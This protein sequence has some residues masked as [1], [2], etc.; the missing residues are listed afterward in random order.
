MSIIRKMAAYIGEALDMIGQDID[1]RIGV[2]A[3]GIKSAILSGLN[4]D[5]ERIVLSVCF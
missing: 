3:T 5:F 1:S 4:S 2:T